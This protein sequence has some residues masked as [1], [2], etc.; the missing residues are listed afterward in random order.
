MKKIL[1]T[2]SRIIIIVLF[3]ALNISIFCS[4]YFADDNISTQ[5]QKSQEQEYILLQQQIEIARSKCTGE[6]PLFAGLY[7]EEPC[8]SCDYQGVI[9]VPVNSSNPCPNRIIVEDDCCGGLYSI[10]PSELERWK[11]FGSADKYCHPNSYC[12]PPLPSNGLHVMIFCFVS[13]Y[14][15][16][17]V[18][19]LWSVKK[20]NAKL[21][22]PS[23]I[24]SVI[25]LIFYV[26]WI[27]GY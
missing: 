5:E 13:V 23:I 10:L 12:D 22:V 26:R 2:L 14:I 16:L 18:G 11:K 20:L 1:L 17:L 27:L 25:F 6:T 4:I 19:F 9:D 3:L 21:A 15:L 24:V 8:V 7:A